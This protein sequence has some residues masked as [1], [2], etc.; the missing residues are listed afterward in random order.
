MKPEEEKRFNQIFFGSIYPQIFDRIYKIL[1]KSINESVSKLPFLP[2]TS[3][4]NSESSK[5][6]LISKLIQIYSSRFEY[7]QLYAENNIFTTGAP[8]IPKHKRKILIDMWKQ[9]VPVCHNEVI[10][11]AKE[12]YESFLNHL[13]NQTNLPNIQQTQQASIDEEIQ[14]LQY[15]KRKLKTINHT[16]TSQL[17]SI[18]K[19]K[20]Y[21]YQVNK[22]VQNEEHDEKLMNLAN[23]I[24]HFDSLVLHCNTLLHEL[25]INVDSSKSTDR[26]NDKD[27]DVF[28]PNDHELDE[29]YEHYTREHQCTLENV[30]NMMDLL[31]EK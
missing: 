31:E 6:K 2:S 19:I 29:D 5:D 20:S 7:V 15:R 9:D 13:Q 16:L 14:K 30:N 21:Q 4:D 23:E 25:N 28:E 26:K 10:D 24:K 1:D 27:M 17:N 11:D 8:F 3:N 12:N 22:I 18:S